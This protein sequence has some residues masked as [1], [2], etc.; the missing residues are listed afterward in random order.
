MIV[1]SVNGFIKFFPQEPED[2]VKFARTFKIDLV[3]ED[4]YF[5]FENLVGLPRYSIAG[6]PYAELLANKT[7]EG[8]HPSDVMLQNTFVYSLLLKR[9]VPMATVPNSVSIK[10]SLWYGVTPAAFLQPGSRVNGSTKR[11]LSYSGWLS[12][13]YQ[14]LYVFERETV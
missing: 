11:I 1:K 2:L 12:L 5:T 6:L 4:D 10:E 7:Y 14:K 9:L 3:R 8:R 13:D